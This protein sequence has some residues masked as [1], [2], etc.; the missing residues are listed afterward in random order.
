MTRP[1]SPLR[2][3]ELVRERNRACRDDRLQE[4]DYAGCEE[5]RTNMRHAVTRLVLVAVIWLVAVS[6][7]VVILYLIALATITGLDT[8]TPE[9]TPTAPLNIQLP[10]T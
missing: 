9:P 2:E 10:T 6:V 8:L 5:C 1:I 4:E 3:Y 7:S